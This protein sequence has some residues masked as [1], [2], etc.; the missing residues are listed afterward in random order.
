VTSVTAPSAALGARLAAGYLCGGLILGAGLGSLLTPFPHPPLAS[1]IVAGFVALAVVTAAA[2]G[3]GRAMGRAA[4]AADLRRMAWAGALGFGPPAIL[5]GVILSLLE[6]VLVGGA[7]GAPGTLPT[8]VVYTLLFVPSM[9]AVPAIA[10]LA[11]G[12]GLRDRPLA[13]RLARDAGLAAAL[14]F[15][16]VDQGM[17]AL[18]WRVGAPDAGRRATMVTVTGIGVLGAALAAGAALGRRLQRGAAVGRN[19]TTTGL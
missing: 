16:A 6:S 18:G 1:E 12:L 11:L 13:W 8:H 15:L 17:D 7:G 2:A 5:A 4:G 19:R 3:W 10:G 9:L 14:V